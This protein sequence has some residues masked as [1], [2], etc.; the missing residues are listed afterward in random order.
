MTVIERHNDMNLSV[1]NRGVARFG[2]LRSRPLFIALAIV[3]GLMIGAAFAVLPTASD[4]KPKGAKKGVF[5]ND[6]P[7]STGTVGGTNGKSARLVKKPKALTWGRYNEYRSNRYIQN[8]TW[9]SW[10]GAVAEGT[11]IDTENNNVSVSIRLSRPK[12]CGPYKMYQVAWITPSRYGREARDVAVKC[13]VVM[14]YRY[15]VPVSW[16]ASASPRGFYLRGRDS[17]LAKW[18]GWGKQRAVGRGPSTKGRQKTVLT[19][20][21]WC[22][23]AGFV[24]YMRS[25]MTYAGKTSVRSYRNVCKKKGLYLPFVP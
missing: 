18:S 12:W 10:G 9:E 17:T 5:Y 24:A 21:A 11:G 22:P 16:N 15:F 3:A 8:I 6:F 25:K 20:L 19:N 7:G 2:G 13:R 1:E 4:A 23:K 14:V